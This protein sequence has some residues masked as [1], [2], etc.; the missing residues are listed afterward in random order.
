MTHGVVMRVVDVT[1]FGIDQDPIET[2]G[3]QDVRQEGG[4]VESAPETEARLLGLQ[5]VLEDCHFGEE[6]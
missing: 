5:V 6:V 4:V 2:T 1:V 3:G